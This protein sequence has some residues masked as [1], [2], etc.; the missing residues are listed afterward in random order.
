MLALGAGGEE[1]QVTPAEEGQQQPLLSA[2]N[3]LLRG[4]FDRFGIFAGGGL[5]PRQQAGA[6]A[7]R[8]R[9]QRWQ[10]PPLRLWLQ[11]ELW[12]LAERQERQKRLEL[13]RAGRGEGFKVACTGPSTYL[14]SRHRRSSKAASNLPRSLKAASE[15]EGG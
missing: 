13:R 6:Q 14:L 15:D 4:S 12:E 10:Q 5:G 8:W 9:S 7:Q 11:G 3:N 2:S 1:Q